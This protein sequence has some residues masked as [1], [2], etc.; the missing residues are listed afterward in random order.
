[1]HHVFVGQNVV[2]AA[3]LRLML[4]AT[5]PHPGV[6]KFRQYTLV[7]TIAKFFNG[8]IFRVQNHRLGIVRDL[9]F[10]LLL[11]ETNKNKAIEQMPE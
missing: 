11:C 6:R 8:W 10:G 4:R 9:A 3:P 1:L 7:Q 5:A 2:F